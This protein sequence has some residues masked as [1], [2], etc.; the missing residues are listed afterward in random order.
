MSFINQDSPV[1]RFIS[2]ATDLFF[3]YVIW[4][5]CCIPIF[6]IGA[7]TTAKYTVSMHIVKD[8]EGNIFKDFFAA[9]KSNFKQSTIIWIINLIFIA[10]CVFD[11]QYILRIGYYDVPIVVRVGAIV[12]S[13]LSLVFYVNVNG[14]IAR[15]EFTTGNAI[16]NGLIFSIL[17]PIRP[18]LLIG[19]VLGSLFAS[20]WYTRW[21]ILILLFGTL[22]AYYMI[23]AFFVKEFGKL[24]KQIE[25]R[26]AKAAEQSKTEDEE[27]DKDC[28]DGD[29]NP[30]SEE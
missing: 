4:F 26:D 13:I 20:L 8:T 30:S 3:V 14:L 23:T 17:H 29:E 21:F 1:M 9:F 16:K 18:I 2:K 11:W 12:L 22:A 5:V 28:S 7:A 15:F 6:T 19:V 24:E 25:E 27:S 10:A